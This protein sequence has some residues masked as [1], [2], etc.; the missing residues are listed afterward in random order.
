M[1]YVSLSNILLILLHLNIGNGT[2]KTNELRQCSKKKRIY[3]NNY[4]LFK[5][6]E[7]LINYFEIRLN[8]LQINFFYFILQFGFPTTSIFC[9][10]KIIFNNFTLIKFFSF[11]IIFY[12]LYLQH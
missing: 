6:I 11:N 2:T 9:F 7:N 12:E 3:T 10:Y 8:S 5:T 1:I 4:N